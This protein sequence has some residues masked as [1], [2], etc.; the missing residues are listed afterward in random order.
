MKKKII[1]IIIV[2]IILILGIIAVIKNSSA[3][4]MPEV[5]ETKEVKKKEFTYSFNYTKKNKVKETKITTIKN[6]DIYYYHDNTLLKVCDGDV[7]IDIQEALSS[8]LITLDKLLES[9]QNS[10]FAYDGGS[11]IYYYD[12]FNIVVCHKVKSNGQTNEN[13]YIG[14]KK[15]NDVS[16]CK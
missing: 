7:C 9:A 3:T 4:T 12:D 6:H 10:S 11:G 5:Q 15:L 13:I 14:K 1:A 16:V 2:I 8:G